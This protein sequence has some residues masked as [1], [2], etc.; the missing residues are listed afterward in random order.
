MKR[1]IAYL[2]DSTGELLE[3][4]SEAVAVFNTGENISVI[5]YRDGSWVFRVR[6]EH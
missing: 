3:K 5:E 1:L 2:V 6:W 4:H